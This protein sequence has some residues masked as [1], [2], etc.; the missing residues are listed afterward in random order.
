ME[1]NAVIEMIKAQSDDIKYSNTALRLLIVLASLGIFGSM[2]CIFMI[3]MSAASQGSQSININFLAGTVI[4][5][6]L[7]IAAV[8]VLCVFDNA[9]R[10]R[11]FENEKTLR[12]NAK[13]FDGKIVGIEKHINHVK[14][15]NEIFD[16]IL[17]NFLVEYKN[18]NNETVTVKGEGF[19]NDITEA[20]ADDSVTVL[21]LEDGTL[22]FE[23]YCL[24][25]KTDDNFIKLT[26]E[27]KEEDKKV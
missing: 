6:G 1:D 26:T 12:K 10:K 22:V 3:V 18:E 14:Y 2:I 21:E 24:R 9:A 4:F 8:V 7:C 25:K 20:L 13:R 15:A 19:L 23:N 11:F 17:Y 16:E 27:V 5:C